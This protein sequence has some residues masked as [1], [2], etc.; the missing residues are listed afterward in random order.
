[1]PDLRSLPKAAPGYRLGKG[2]ILILAASVVLL[3]GLIQIDAGSVSRPPPDFGSMPVEQKK[4]EFFAYLSPLI[5]QVN[6][7][8]VADRERVHALREKL[9][10]GQAPGW[11]DRRWLNQLAAR[12]EVPIDELE[13]DEALEILERRAGVV[14]ESIVLVQAAMESGWGT[15][16]FAREGN[17]Y[18]GQRCYRSDCGMQPQS[19]PEDADFGL[20]R[21]SSVSASVES[22]I[23]NLNTHPEYSEFRK[24]RERLRET[25]APITGLAL[26]NG[27]S[28][29]SERGADYVA[30][31]ADMIRANQLE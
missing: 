20:A 5:S 27:L 15:S 7:S 3:A 10:R 1:M 13:L 4:R 23:L 25:G 31:I 12:L 9:E 16:R 6:F 24:I 8:M 17:N 22:Y 19:R 28:A 14:P 2:D 26:V 30:E 11:S 18:F 21:F 29:Y